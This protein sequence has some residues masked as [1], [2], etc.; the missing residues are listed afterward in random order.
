MPTPIQ[1]VTSFTQQALEQERPRDQ[2][3]VP[4][5][6]V[7]LDL[8][9]A[10]VTYTSTCVAATNHKGRKSKGSVQAYLH[11]ETGMHAVN[12]S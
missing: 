11:N 6:G 10:N 4:R 2:V 5:P 7:E 3:T 8:L 12:K 9:Q 1:T